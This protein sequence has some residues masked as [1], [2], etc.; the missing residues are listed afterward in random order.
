MNK[1]CL[2]IFKLSNHIPK[3]SFHQLPLDILETLNLS[4][5]SLHKTG[6]NELTFIGLSNLKELKL[7]SNMSYKQ[8][9][10]VSRKKK[11]SCFKL[12]NHFFYN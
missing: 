1:I 6:L 7:N 3:N 12:N 2:K 5:S 9:K 8:I 11:T 10:T 4:R